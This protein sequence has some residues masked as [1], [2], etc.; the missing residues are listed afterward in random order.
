[1]G[2][3]AQ[4]VVKEVPQPVPQPRTIP[5]LKDKVK[6]VPPLDFIGE[7][8]AAA[9]DI[10]VRGGPGTDYTVVGQLQRG[11]EVRVVGKVI[12]R[13]WYMISQNGAGSGFVSANLLKPMGKAA[14][15][16][17]PQ[18][19]APANADVAQATVAASSTCRVVTQQVTK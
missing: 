13:D 6:Q 4:T 15:A 18:T 17:K 9:D 16:Q 14:V 1:T 2:V 19:A 3:R 5:V 7:D 10:N 12:D 11:A 8:Y